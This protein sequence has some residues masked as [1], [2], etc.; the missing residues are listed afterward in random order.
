[1]WPVNGKSSPAQK[2]LLGYILEYRDAIIARIRLGV[3]VEQI[4]KETALWMEPV[5]A[6]EKFSLPK[7][8]KAPA[9]CSKPAAA[10]SPSTRNSA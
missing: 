2:E 3:T 8:E 9:R 5:F 7:H 1:M 10:S 6:R 4:R